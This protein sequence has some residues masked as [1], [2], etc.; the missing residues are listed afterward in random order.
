MFPQ[1]ALTMLA[2]G[3]GDGTPSLRSQAIALFDGGVRG[4]LLDLTHATK[5]FQEQTGASATTPAGVGDPVGTIASSV[6]GYYAVV[7]GASTKRPVLGQDATG[8]YLQFTSASSQILQ[9][10]S[11]VLSNRYYVCRG[12]E[13]GA[14]NQFLLEHSA[15]APSAN[16]FVID[17]LTGDCW[18]T[19]RGG[20][21]H[22]GAP[23]SGTWIGTDLTIAELIY[24]AS[25]QTALA[26][27]EEVV[28]GSHSGVL[29]AQSDVTATLNIGG[30]NN[31][32]LFFN[33]KLRGGLAIWDGNITDEQATIFRLWMSEASGIAVPF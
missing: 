16:G 21:N 29:A 7:P 19:S 24:R 27:G 5:L 15:S 22:I 28:L 30:R 3:G 17:D 12:V 13:N 31:T 20:A 32:S 26:N 23:S 18:L 6:N 25:D 2:S 10:A 11:F 33:G 4:A 14:S 9:I 8:R 1:I